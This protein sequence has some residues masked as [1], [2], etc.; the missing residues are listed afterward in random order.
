M[1]K[2]I[3]YYLALQSPFAY[4][5]HERLLEIAARHSATIHIRPVQLPKVFA[6]TG[7]VPLPQR[8]PERRAYR[9]VELRRWRDHFG[10]PLNLEPRHF[11]T[12]ERLAAGAVIALREAHGDAPAL[13][14]AGAILRAVW[15]EE[16]DIADAE[17]LA[18]IAE[19]QGLDAGW[20]LERAASEEMAERWEQNTQDAI[21]R[22]VFG[23]PSYIYDDELFW[24][25][26]RLEFLERALARS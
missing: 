19:A 11:P 8:A 23:S 1:A 20:L 15:A 22:G 9:L 14:L 17:T 12:D 5:G 13:H 3:D 26:D 4:L 21:A 18:A 2:T 16:R 6:A 25:Q 10:V 24:G 7:G